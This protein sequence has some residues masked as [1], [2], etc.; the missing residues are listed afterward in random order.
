MC[1]ADLPKNLPNSALTQ[2]KVSTSGTL[3]ARRDVY[4]LS[5]GYGYETSVGMVFRQVKVDVLL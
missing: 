4:A 3:N 5:L 2:Q 1:L